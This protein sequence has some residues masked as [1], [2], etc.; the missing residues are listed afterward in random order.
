MDVDEEP[1]SKFTSFSQVIKELDD[2]KLFLEDRGSTNEANAVN[3]AVDM[4]A[5]V[6]NASMKQTTLQD[7]FALQPEIGNP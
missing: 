2:I 5:S 4:V 1:V 3:S 6:H 7:F